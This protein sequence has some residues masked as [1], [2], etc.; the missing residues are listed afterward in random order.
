MI[1]IRVKIKL[2]NLSKFFDQEQTQVVKDFITFLQKELVLED[3]VTIVFSN[4]RPHDMTTG[5]RI[6]PNMIYILSRDRMIAD[7]LRTISHEWVHEY[8][9]QKL[10]LRDDK[11][12]QNIGGQV[13]NMANTLAGI[14]FKKFER[15]NP[16]SKKI[17]YNE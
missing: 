9:H 11:Q 8:Q 12:Y 15:D 13:E 3:P 17:I 6:T 10:G 2:K 7:I 14:L 4:D 5:L 16:E 1:F